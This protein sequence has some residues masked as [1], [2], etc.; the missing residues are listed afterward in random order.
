MIRPQGRTSPPSD[1]DATGRVINAHLADARAAYLRLAAKQARRAE[2]AQHD[3]SGELLLD[4]RSQDGPRRTY[5]DPAFAH[6]PG[7]ITL[8]RYTPSESSQLRFAAGVGVAYERRALDGPGPM[9]Q[10]RVTL[11]LEHRWNVSDSHAAIDLVFQ[12]PFFVG[13]NPLSSFGAGVALGVR[14]AIE[15]PRWRM[16]TIHEIAPVL[17]FP[18]LFQGLTADATQPASGR[19]LCAQA[20]CSSYVM[21]PA[22]LIAYGARP[23]FSRESKIAPLELRVEVGVDVGLV[24]GQLY[25]PRLITGAAILWRFPLERDLPQ[26]R[27]KGAR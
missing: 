23:R 18:F 8:L 13:V 25:P 6:H 14:G 24:D 1:R 16:V 17:L 12:V 26:P 11:N 3:T 9:N 20:A 27:I 2:R 4:E 10:L 15:L 21:R 19:P 5:R 22:F 7:A